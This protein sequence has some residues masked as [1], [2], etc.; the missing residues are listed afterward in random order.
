MSSACDT[1]AACVIAT[2]VGRPLPL[3]CV[4]EPKGHNFA[5]FSRHAER[6]RLLLFDVDAPHEPW[7]SFDLGPSCHRTGD[8]WHVR[9]DGVPPGTAYAWRADGP[10]DLSKGHRFDVGERLLDPYAQAL[11]GTGWRSSGSSGGDAAVKPLCLV[12]EPDSFDWQGDC[13]LRH[14][15]SE[16]IIYET[17][18]RGLSIAPSSGVVHPG[19]FLGVIEKIP[20]FL[21]LGIT[22]IELM[23]V[24][25]FLDE[26]LAR[27]DQKTGR[28]PSN[29]W[30]YNTMAFFAPKEGYSTRRVAGGQV[31]EFK[32][33]V[34]AL[35]AAG[36]EVIL[37]VVFNHTGEGDDGGPTLNYRGLEN[38]IYYLLD[39]ADKSRYL[40]YSGCGNTFNCSHPVVRDHVLDCLRYWTAE[41]HVDGFRF[42]LASV[43]G[44]GPNGELLADPPLLERIAEDPILRHVKLIAEAWDAGGAYQ[45]GSFSGHRWSEWNGRYRDDVR[46]FWRGDPGMT[47]AFASR[48]CGSADVYQHSGK[49]PLHSINFVTCHD[50]L[51]LND[52]VSYREK[53]NEANGE[54]NRDGTDANFSANYGIEGDT[55][56]PEI[57]ALRVRQIKNLLATL[58]LSR[59]VPML[60]GGD[61]IRRTQRGNNN[62]Y[63]QDNS[64][65]WYDWS[66]LETHRDIFDF[67]ARLIA[68]RQRHAVL[69]SARFYTDSELIWFDAEGHSPDWDTATSVGCAIRAA[70][71]TPSLCLL[72]NPDVEA[73]IFRLP[74]GVRQYNWLPAIDTATSMPTPVADD[75][76]GS[77]QL[78]SRSL[79]VLERAERIHAAVPL[80]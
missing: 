36:I 74:E 56:D 1:P 61:E 28:P 49:K 9:L 22:A 11:V 70:D 23:P 52:L 30:G 24:H 33:M 43:L 72:F 20:Y 40:D 50:G 29:Y 4:A 12:A 68:F 32:E 31:N 10:F 27:R 76:I 41:M 17:H 47:G 15:W 19:T 39:P 14:D 2:A 66:L 42:D 21:E 18:V 60:L 71:G 46:R 3:G 54:G 35:H 78:H 6:M 77:W 37:D 8:V 64:V 13:P 53:H 45:V 5:V 75:T 73:R 63:C 16:T 7:F 44:R 62:A 67:T 38:T 48:L 58:M 51:T 59:G 79:Q 69:R 26:E 55:E 34:R 25:E 57:E 65:S 80:S